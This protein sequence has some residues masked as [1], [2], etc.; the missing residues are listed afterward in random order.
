MKGG[1]EST[2]LPQILF[3]STHYA[4]EI[5]QWGFHSENL[6]KIFRPHYARESS[7][8]NDNGHFGIVFEGNQGNHVIIFTSSF[9]E[10]FVFIM[11]S[12]HTITQNPRFQI[13]PVWGAFSK[14]SV[15]VKGK[16][17]ISAKIKLSSQI[18]LALCGPD[19][20][21]YQITRYNY[22]CYSIQIQDMRLFEQQ[23]LKR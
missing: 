3:L 14:S 10:S 23:D 7:Q 1:I 18:S 2:K 9:S 5:S 13:P 15:V 4:K 22:H 8:R 21:D 17:G 20:I 12:V 19:L 6:A 16:C 11:F